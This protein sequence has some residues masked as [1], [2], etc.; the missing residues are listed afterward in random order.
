MTAEEPTPA[1]LILVSGRRVGLGGL[2]RDL[3][4]TYARWRTDLEVFLG[5]GNN[6]QVPTIE[7]ME[8]W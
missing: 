6:G 4:A 2:R 8:A 7:A 1:P 5:A 3:I